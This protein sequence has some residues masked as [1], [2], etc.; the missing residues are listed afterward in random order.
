MKQCHKCG[1]ELALSEFREYKDGKFRGEC[2]VCESEQGKKKRAA[3]KEA[4]D[5]PGVCQCCLKETRELVVD[6]CHDTGRFRGW[7]CR[8]CNSGIGKLGDN[9][10]GVLRAY[11]Y[12]L[13]AE[14]D[15]HCTTQLLPLEFIRGATEGSY[16]TQNNK[17]TL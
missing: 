3:H 6:H 8:N 7:L 5:N 15:D 2:R 4:G 16:E 1:Q 13:K 12:L 10:D 9:S 17:E 11:L 14:G